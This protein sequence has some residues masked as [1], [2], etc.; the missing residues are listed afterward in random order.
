MWF[1]IQGKDDRLTITP[2]GLEI[3][4]QEVSHET[5]G[6]VLMA[7]IGDLNRDNYPEIMVYISADGSG[8]YGSI[9]GYSVNNGKSMSQIYLP[10]LSEKPEISEKIRK[11]IEL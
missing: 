7:E 6:T 11:V 1:T 8:S 9:I 2:H 10:D 5:Y 4:N 3:N